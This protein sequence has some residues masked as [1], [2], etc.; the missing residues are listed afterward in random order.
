VTVC[1]TEV[2]DQWKRKKQTKK[3]AQEARK[4]KLDPSSA[5][6]VKDVMDENDRKRKRELDGDDYDA[7]T[8]GQERPGEGLKK[9]KKLKYL[10]KEQK[11]ALAAQEGGIP[12]VF[13]NTKKP[14]NAQKQEERKQKLEERK[15]RKIAR[16]EKLRLK[17]GPS[18]PSEGGKGNRKKQKSGSPEILFWLDNANKSIDIKKPAHLLTELMSGAMAVEPLQEREQEEP[19]EL[20]EV[21]AQDPPEDTVSED[22]EEEEEDIQSSRQ[23]SPEVFMALDLSGAASASSSISSVIPLDE[24]SKPKVESLDREKL[25]SRLEARVFELRAARN[26]NG[27]EGKVPRN[28]QELLEQ[29]RQKEEKRKALKKEQRRKAKE[30]ERSQLLNSASGSHENLPISAD[31]KSHIAHNLLFGRIAFDD[32]DSMAAD[33]SKMLDKKKRRGPSDAQGALKRAEGKLSRIAGYDEGKKAD[34]AEK[35]LWLHAKLKAT[36]DKVRDDIGLLKKTLKRQ[37][38]AKQKSESEWNTRIEGVKKGIEMR[39]KKREDNLK[40]RRDEKGNKG[41]K[42]KTG[43]AKK[44]KNRPGFEGSFTSKARRSKT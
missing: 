38:K 40:K 9:A 4:A 18:K 37:E 26:A 12:K 41:K 1:L 8:E 24:P 31:S 21:E 30:E 22:E 33:L 44:S 19:E 17:Y 5:K 34:I 16:A 2:Q 32:G 10:P 36:G 23:T 3:Q 20:E 39:Q 11:A 7:T 15:Q 42:K 35:D 29:R 28:R 43:S 25:K 6:T 13:T 14:S 27:E